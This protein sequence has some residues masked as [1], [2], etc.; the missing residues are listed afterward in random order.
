MS[1]SQSVAS[2]PLSADPDSLSAAQ[3]NILASSEEN[4]RRLNVDLVKRYLALFADYVANMTSGG[5]VPPERQIPPSPPMAWQLA[6][7]DADGFVWYEVG[8]TPACPQPPTPAYN[9]DNPQPNTVPNMIMIGGQNGNTAWY[10]ALKGDTFPSGMTT[11]P[12]P[13]GHTYEKFGAPVGPGWY[14]QLPGAVAPADKTTEKAT[15]EKAPF[16]PPAEF[17]A[18]RVE[19]APAPAPLEVEKVLQEPATF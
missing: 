17:V 3:A 11:P 4:V 15:A 7:P 19:K 9:H 8:S 13:D 14:L 18:A 2:L 5:F 10:T 16:V 12:Q 1:T 6:A